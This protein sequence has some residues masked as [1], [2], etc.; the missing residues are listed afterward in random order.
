MD[1][2]IIVAPYA[3]VAVAVARGRHRLSLAI[4]VLK[5]KI[6]L[7]TF[8]TRGVG[9]VSLVYEEVLVRIFFIL[10]RTTKH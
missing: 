7:T 10:T 6:P 9:T 4:V 5:K 8:T 1:V 3:M 2:F